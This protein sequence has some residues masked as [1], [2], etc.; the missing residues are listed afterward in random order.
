VIARIAASSVPI[1]QVNAEFDPDNFR[2]FGKELD[3][4]LTKAGRTHPY[5]ILKDHDHLSEG[6]AVG[7]SDVSL[8]APLLT[9][10]EAL[11]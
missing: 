7:T 4:G 6:F 3:E 8:T 5:L 10:I 9:W 11:H 2:S 1:F